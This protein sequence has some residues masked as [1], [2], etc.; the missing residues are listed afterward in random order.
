MPWA[1]ACGLLA[2][3]GHA[4]AASPEVPVELRASRDYVFGLVANHSVNPLGTDDYRLGVAPVFAFQ[5]GRLRFA[6][7]GASALLS[8]GREDVD[9]GV[10]TALVERSNF[11]LGA[12]LQFDPGRSADD[13]LPEVPRT[14]RG[15]LNL[16]YDLGGRWSVRTTVSHDLL[17]KAGGTRVGASLHY[18]HPLSPYTHWDVS[19]G[20]DWGS[21]EF[22]RTRY[23]IGADWAASHGLAVYAPGA[24]WNS[25]SL[26][27]GM[28]SALTDDWVMFGGVGVS[29]L[30]GAAA[31]SPLRV[32]RTTGSLNV[33]LAYR[34][35][36]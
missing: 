31:D 15:R 27:W 9:P 1:L 4:V 32:R 8:L 34:C 22:M 16:G 11:R 29:Q 35:C 17:D 25:R 19:L 20:A 10:S 6:T 24:G 3:G 14:L 18:R 5:V 13:R 28:T 2:C 7:G 36:S 12:S 23:G 33:G 26:G 21:R 30:L